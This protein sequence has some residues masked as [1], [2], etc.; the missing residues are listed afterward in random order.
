MNAPPPAAPAAATLHRRITDEIRGKIL[1]GA[2]P[3]GQRIPREHDLMARYGCARMTVSKALTALV[4]AGLVE[5]RRR[6]GSFVARPPVQS[7]V[8][9]IPDIREEVERRGHVYGLELLTSERRR[10]TAADRALIPVDAGDPLLALACRHGADGR[11]FALEHRLISL[12]AVPEAADVDFAREPPGSWLLRHVPWNEATHEIAAVE[13]D[14]EV[15]AA[16]AIAPGRACLALERT[17]WRGASPITHVRLI[18]PSDRMR[19]VANFTPARAGRRPDP[20]Q[21]GAG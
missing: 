10:A 6:A 1:S 4:A 9:E 5:R 8:L 3:P 16:L 7:A 11:P 19:L 13:A 20:E 18:F 2:W 14:A 12:A 17:T 15:A 21:N